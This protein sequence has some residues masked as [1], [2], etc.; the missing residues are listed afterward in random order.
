MDTNA[1]GQGAGILHVAKLYST[2]ISYWFDMLPESCH[3]LVRVTTYVCMKCPVSILQIGPVLN[4]FFGYKYKYHFHAQQ[5]LSSKCHKFD[6]WTIHVVGTHVS[7][8]FSLYGKAADTEAFWHGVA[9]GVCYECFILPADSGMMPQLY[10]PLLCHGMRMV[11]WETHKNA[12]AT[13]THD[14]RWPSI[15]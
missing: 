12:T 8:S 14:D 15:Y 5:Y 11:L 3:A 2:C 6:P 13:R 4:Y 10:E 9:E 1:S 7:L